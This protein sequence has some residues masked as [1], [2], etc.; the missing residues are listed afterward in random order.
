MS[1]PPKKRPRVYSTHGL[2]TLKAAVRAAGDNWL[3]TLGPVGQALKEWQD[4]IIADLGGPAA[5][6]A[7][8]RALVQLATR[9]HL[10]LESIDRFLLEQP[11]LVNKSR[12]QLFPVVLQRQQLADAL[13]RYVNLLGL[14]RR[15]RPM[16]SLNE[17][18]Q[19]RAGEQGRAPES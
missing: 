18:L 9:T 11:S 12:R 5:I 3:D 2:C 8:Q 6:S 10:F 13:A 7:Q 15:S 17:Y 14:E 19:G 4:E 16:P 1:R